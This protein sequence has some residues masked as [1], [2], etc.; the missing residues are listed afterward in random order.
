MCSFKLI[1][2]IVFLFN[3][4]NTHCLISDK[5]LCVN[6][7][8]SEPISLAKTLLGYNRPEK[9]ML[10]FRPN[11]NIKVFS[12]EAGSRP[13]LW[14]VEIN[15]ERG[16]IPQSYVREYKILAKPTVVVETEI[17][18]K[19]SEPQDTLEEEVNPDKV[20][21]SFEVVDG[22]TILLDPAD[23]S[24]SSTENPILS[25]VSSTSSSQ[26]TPT[27]ENPITEEK[28][29]DD[30]EDGKTEKLPQPSLETEAE[31]KN[32]DSVVGGVF[33]SIK[34]WIN[35]DESPEDDEEEDDDEDSD[36]EEDA[37]EDD[38]EDVYVDSK[39]KLTGS[40]SEKGSTVEE[41]PKENVVEVKENSA[42]AT[43]KPEVKPNKIEE[44]E[45]EKPTESK[46]NEISENE[47]SKDQVGQAESKKD[48]LSK[49]QVTQSE[50]KKN[51]ISE[52]ESNNKVSQSEAD[53]KF[54]DL[55]QKEE[56]SGESKSDV[57]PLKTA[58]DIIVEKQKQEEGFE[59]NKS[60]DGV[61]STGSEEVIDVSKTEHSDPTKT[62]ATET[63]NKLNTDDN[64]KNTEDT[65][66]KAVQGSVENIK[67]K[68]SVIDVID[69][70][71]EVK[72]EE[73]STE[74]VTELPI[75]ATTLTNMDQ[76]EFI[77]VVP[78]ETVTP[79]PIEQMQELKPQGTI[80]SP[81]VASLYDK[82]PDDKVVEKP[83]VVE[84]DSIHSNSSSEVN[85]VNPGVSENDNLTSDTS[86]PDVNQLLSSP[87]SKYGA[88]TNLEESKSEN[89]D[90]SGSS[91]EQ[92]LKTPVIGF[93]PSEV[94][95]P[96]IEVPPPQDTPLNGIP[97]SPETHSSN[98]WHS[99]ENPNKDI[100]AEI[101][102]VDRPVIRN[103][104][105]NQ[106]PDAPSDAEI[107]ALKNNDGA[108]PNN[109]LGENLDEGVVIEETI[110]VESGGFLSG[111]FSFFGGDKRK[112]ETVETHSTPVS[113]ADRLIHE[114]NQHS[115]YRKENSDY[116]LSREENCD[117]LEN[118]SM[119]EKLVFLMSSDI[120]IYLGTTAVSCIIFLFAYLL[121]DKSSREA[122]LVQ[123]IN[124]LEK[125][126]LV[127]MKENDILQE[128]ASTGT[129]VPSEE[130]DLLKQQLAE[131]E[132]LRQTLEMQVLSLQKETEN[133]NELEDQI[134]SLEKELESS[135][136]VGMELNR[137][138]SEMLDSNNGGEKLKEN[139]EQLHRQLLEQKSIIN[140]ISKSL[141][142]KEEESAGLQAQLDE[143]KKHCTDLQQKLDEIVDQ[144][145]RIERERDQQEKSLQEE[146]SIYR[147]KCSEEM[148]KK[149]MFS[150]E[151]KIL[152][153][154]LADAQRKADL[155]I[156][157]YQ[158][159]KDSLKDIKS[160][161][162]DNAAL[163]S[164]L[165]ATSIKAELEQLKSE[166][167]RY[168]L[169]IK[170]EEDAKILF[171]KKCQAVIDEN[172]DLLKK[173]QESDKEKVEATMKLEVLN[174]YFKKREEELQSEILKYKTIWD[175]KEGE[176]TSTTER[177]K[178]MA[179]ETENYKSQNETL[180]QEIVSQEIELKSQISMLEKK[181]HDNWVTSRQMERKLEDS[182]QETALLRNRL[183]LRER[184]MIDERTQNR[185]QSPV[186][187]NGELTF[188][189]VAIESP[190][191]PAMLFGGRD[192]ITKSPPI[193]GL[194]PFLPPPPGAPFMPPPLPGMPFMPPPPSMFPGDHRPPPLGR[195]SSPPPLNSR[196]SPDTSA[197][198]PYD[199]HTPSPPYDS[200]YGA[201]PPPMRG[202]S[203]YSRDD[204]RDYKRPMHI[205]N[206]RS[207]KGSLMSSG[208]DHSNDSLDK[209]NRKSSKMV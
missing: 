17:S 46:K 158:S 77:P 114:N 195:M 149:E 143:S 205:S 164:L 151:I 5:R 198:S 102:N 10:S 92:L 131:Q 27:T 126:L 209:V 38:E 194:P 166:N 35:D 45:K 145:L 37:E 13:D 64:N 4:Y 69:V 79:D 106:I 26:E 176:A 54:N 28:I 58:N 181:V 177:M 91:A 137:I 103:N 57:D 148:M 55:K 204:R 98:H 115:S 113:N 85:K 178:L 53:N 208:S 116:Y 117:T 155:K 185:L 43:N 141:S 8:C 206:G 18:Q 189:P 1:C 83:E 48:E 59:V 52:N 134:E 21:E 99:N 172:N 66:D 154:Q 200:E 16:Y 123:K 90:Q 121:I 63:N 157:E 97:L 84:T 32:E 31:V 9:Y 76:I 68:E 170:Q 89:V 14:G 125:E 93:W 19:P 101:N 135:T 184:A 136:E 94:N 67:L 15:G 72:A 44:S 100:A 25:T 12:K 47:S 171:E 152:K 156:K 50:S 193:P 153:T 180:K 190:A 109:L 80:Y 22:T 128:S 168:S 51:E 33:S 36:D 191:S 150:N 140:D 183:T 124:K 129:H 179:E 39:E 161:K 3:I 159:L 105:D 127:I 86:S 119:L 199:R 138:I 186:D 175:A 165:D 61:K 146:I 6:E 56:D 187:Q 60:E 142:D 11:T 139:V 182:R 41:I 144:I 163:Q 74:S 40:D 20:K 73:K 120:L 132:V 78:T 104:D 23:I 7:D 110:F 196:Y 133:K 96:K 111:I 201:S 71:Q 65:A 112:H 42:E 122:P 130:V 87:E 162:N 174:N 30:K 169:I 188:S 62:D 75:D 107:N 88:N 34:N 167:E 49:D 29:S 173:Y 207:N 192:H 160:I 70:L 24:P 118:N 108:L 203:P 95:K 147:Q 2:F 81:I 197:F 82:K 202:Y